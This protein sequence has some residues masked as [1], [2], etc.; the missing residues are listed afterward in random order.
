MSLTTLL[1]AFGR[2]LASFRTINVGQPKLA[3]DYQI[4]T[5]GGAN[6]EPF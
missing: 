6:T 4:A 1:R 2:I 5:W 3:N